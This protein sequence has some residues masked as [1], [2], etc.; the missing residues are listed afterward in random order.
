MLAMVC[1][2]TSLCL[3]LHREQARSYRVMCYQFEVLAICV[4]DARQI[5]R[6]V[7]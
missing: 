4:S 5:S 3:M 6:V 2:T 1:Q 7:S